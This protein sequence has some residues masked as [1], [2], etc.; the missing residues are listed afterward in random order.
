VLHRRKV[1]KL[2]VMGENILLSEAK[3]KQ[4]AGMTS[5]A[6]FLADQTIF[7]TGATGSLSYIY[8]IFTSPLVSQIFYRIITP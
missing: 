6:D 2:S 3:P 4:E 1:I 7:V 8:R 5:I